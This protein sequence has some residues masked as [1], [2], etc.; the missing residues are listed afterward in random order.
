M[1]ADRFQGRFQRRHVAFAA[2]H[3]AQFLLQEIA[4]H[5][6]DHAIRQIEHLAVIGCGQRLLVA[7]TAADQDIDLRIFSLDRR[8]TAIEQRNLPVRARRRSLATDHELARFAI[9]AFAI[10]NDGR[11]H[12]AYEPDPHDD[13]DFLAA[14][15]G[16]LGKSP[17]TLVLGSIRRW[18]RQ[19]ERLAVRRN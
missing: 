4:L 12:G 19:R 9:S 14:R 2:P 16:S 11:H 13:D 6:D 1:L 8:Y 3:V 10:G 5:V 18:L 7:H 17:D 15:P